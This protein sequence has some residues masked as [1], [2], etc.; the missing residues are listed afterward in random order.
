MEHVYYLYKSGREANFLHD[1]LKDFGGVLIS[2]FYTGYDSLPCLQQKCLVHLIRDIND[3]MLKNPFDSELKE[4]AML[5]GHLVRS[6][7]LTID[8]V[9]LKA[10][11]LRKFKP[12]VEEFI[13]LLTLKDIRSDVA[14]KY[15]KRILKYQSKLFTFLE[16]D[17]VPWNNNNAEHAV[18]H[19]AKY[20]RLTN[21][22]ITESGLNNYLVLL[23]IYQT[24]RYRE[25]KF[26]D[27]LLSRM[28]DIDCFDRAMVGQRR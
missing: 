17:G 27:F 13:R 18:K 19:F 6:V 10:A 22:R 4:V 11:H 25:I 3:D 23:S 15:C 2:D 5:F 9:G 26:L 24:C 12:R 7:V 21:G 16:H 8:K 28:R 1:T 20:R 14:Q